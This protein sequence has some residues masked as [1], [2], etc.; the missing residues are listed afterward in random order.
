MNIKRFSF[1]FCYLLVAI[2]IFFFWNKQNNQ[3]KQVKA[4]TPTQETKLQQLKTPIWSV[5][6]LEAYKIYIEN[7]DELAR[8]QERKFYMRPPFYDGP[9]PLIVE[10][11]VKPTVPSAMPGVTISHSFNAFQTYFVYRDSALKFSGI[12]EGA[13]TID[14]T[15]LVAEAQFLRLI[16]DENQQFQG[17][18]IEEFHWGPMAS[19]YSSARAELTRGAS[20]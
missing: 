4:S 15:G 1:S 6:D 9:M 17:I 16:K 5:K 18:E 3:L 13:V 8:V 10:C 20:R 19:S 12:A 7:P 11:V 2:A 14:D